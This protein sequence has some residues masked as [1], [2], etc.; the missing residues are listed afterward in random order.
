VPEATAVQRRLSVAITVFSL[1]GAC[2][3]DQTSAPERGPITQED[4]SAA[5]VPDD[6]G[7]GSNG[8]P[9]ESLPGESAAR[10]ATIRLDG[11]R[12]AGCF[13]DAD[14]KGDGLVCFLHTGSR[15]CAGVLKSPTGVTATTS[16][17]V[18]ACQIDCTA[19]G[20]T[21]PCSVSC[22][23]VGQSPFTESFRCVTLPLT[24]RAS[25]HGEDGQLGLA[26]Q[27]L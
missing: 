15:D 6:D 9:S 27:G 18:G 26:D 13:D 7:E 5:S 1:L 10:P 22:R 17:D 19:G 23:D 2:G 24:L 25:V 16:C 4:A 21:C 3:G 20:A 8:K 12:G 11:Q 14:C